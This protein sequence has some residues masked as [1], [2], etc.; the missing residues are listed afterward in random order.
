[1]KW[2]NIDNQGYIVDNRF[3][4]RPL[5]EKPAI[6]IYKLKDLNECYIGATFNVSRRFRQHKYRASQHQTK[7]LYNTL[8]YNAVA[9]YGWENFQFSI[10]QYIDIENNT[11]SKPEKMLLFQLEQEYINRYSPSFNINNNRSSKWNNLSYLKKLGINNNKNNTSI[12]PTMSNETIKKLKMHKNISLSIYDKNNQFIIKFNRIKHAAEYVGRSYTTVSKYAKMGK[13]WNN[14]FYFKINVNK[15]LDYL[16]LNFPLDKNI[17]KPIEVTKH[18]VDKRSHYLEVS[19]NEHIIY[20][21]GSLKEASLFLN[22][23][24]T[25]LLK[26][27]KTGKLWK[28]KF[29]FKIIVNK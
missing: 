8:F 29:L 7:R 4:I 16:N 18:K 2:Y 19:V 28:N 3:I 10:L 22:I 21:F 11:I 27:A 26:Y 9:Q 20:R 5:L 13:L 6:Y 1:M 14:L 17:F 12:H 25:T 15:D 23:S 24:K